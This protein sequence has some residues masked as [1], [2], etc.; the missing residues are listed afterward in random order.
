MLELLIQ[1]LDRVY[2]DLDALKERE[3]NVK[4]GQKL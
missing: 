4:G 2:E 1:E 3:Y